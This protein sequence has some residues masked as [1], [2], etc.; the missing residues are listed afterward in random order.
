MER[1]LV[2]NASY[3]PMN[4]VGWHRAITLLYLNKVEVLE[5]YDYEVR[6]V[7]LS[8]KVPSVLRLVSFIPQKRMRRRLKLTRTNVFIRDRYR[9]QYC[10]KEF[11]PSQLTLDH[12][13]PLNHGGYHSWENLVTACK[14]CNNRKGGK[15]PREAGMKLIREPRIPSYFIGSKF[16]VDPAYIP[17]NWR[18]YLCLQ[19]TK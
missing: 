11:S 8:L 16:I 10:G 7:S 1:T 2:L 3:E 14:E 9:C 4:V 5:E 18:V 15:A 17:G 12:V 13:I 6:S 19:G